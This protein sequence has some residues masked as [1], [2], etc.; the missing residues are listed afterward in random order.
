MSDINNKESPLNAIRNYY[1][2]PKKALNRLD[3]ATTNKL[4]KE[5]Y[6]LIYSI[7]KRYTSLGFSKE[8]LFAEGVMGLLTAQEKFDNEKG[9]KFS[10]YAFYW[11]KAQMLSFVS[12]FKRK[13][14]HP[15]NSIDNNNENNNAF[16]EVNHYIPHPVEILTDFA[17][18]E[19][20]ITEQ[21]NKNSVEN[22]WSEE[23]K[24]KIRTAVSLLNHN[25]RKVITERWLDDNKTLIA[26]G[27][28]MH[29]SAERVRQIEK[30]AME[31]IRKLLQNVFTEKEAY[32]IFSSFFF[33][34]LSICEKQ[35]SFT[36]PIAI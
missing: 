3:Q 19:K 9:I 16:N 13:V 33:D 21:H 11:I 23:I 1:E 28:E 12:K 18:I 25:E 5:H 27:S 17:F 32:I 30:R 8:E 6:K 15:Q 7:A 31:K 26:L 4:L 10:T 24:A 20:E 14:Y 36:D 34:F 35:G 29:I 2:S 22:S